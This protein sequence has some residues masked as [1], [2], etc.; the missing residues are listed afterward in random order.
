MA[1]YQGY[2]ERGLPS[3]KE[4]HRVEPKSTSLTG[5]CIGMFACLT[6]GLG[7]GGVQI[8]WGVGVTWGDALCAG[9]GL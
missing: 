5:L 2:R 6:A 4:D 8:V 3:E 9:V 1:W 7:E